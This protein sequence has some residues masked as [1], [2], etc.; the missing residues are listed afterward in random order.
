LKL[1]KNKKGT[2]EGELEEQKMA[3]TQAPR[4]QSPVES[5]IEDLSRTQTFYKHTAAAK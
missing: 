2:Q 1:K 3:S 4:D 5:A